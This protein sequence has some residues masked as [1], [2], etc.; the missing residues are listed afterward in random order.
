MQKLSNDKMSIDKINLINTLPH[1]F[2]RE[3]ISSEVWQ[4]KICLERGRFY[5]I[6]AASGTGKSSLCSY[7]YGNRTDY[8]GSILFDETDI[9]KFNIA[10]WQKLRRKSI[11]Y[12]P[13]ELSLFPELTAIQN[14]H[15]KN[16]LTNHASESQIKNWFEELGIS[17]RMDYPV[18]KMSTGQQQRVAIIRAICQPFSFLIL[19]EP[20]SHLDESNNAIVARLVS[21]EARKQGACVIATSVG[22]NLKIDSD[23]IFKL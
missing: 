13:Q 8:F 18:G 10:K 9:S 14:V 17:D 12:L 3:V 20:V 1:V 11:A 4:Q 6:E 7:I 19:D 23:V 22:N 15:L 5:L 16:T 21:E 2:E